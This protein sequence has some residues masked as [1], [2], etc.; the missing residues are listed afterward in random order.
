MA[1]YVNTTEGDKLPK[2]ID[3]SLGIRLQWLT[4]IYPSFHRL[5]NEA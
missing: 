5:I 3:C 1:P 4:T 2:I